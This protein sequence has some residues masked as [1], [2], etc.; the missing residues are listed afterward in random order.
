MSFIFRGLTR[1]YLCRF[2]SPGEYYPGLS[3]LQADRLHSCVR[4]PCPI[5]GGEVV[6]LIVHRL[7]KGNIA[8]AYAQRYDNRTERKVI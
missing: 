6:A 7:E 4:S 3:L 2:F 1:L 5:P 8:T